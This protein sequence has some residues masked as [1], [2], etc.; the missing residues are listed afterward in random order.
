MDLEQILMLLAQLS[1][2]KSSNKSDLDVLL[3]P[4]LG[5]F[6]GTFQQ[7][8]NPKYDQEFLRQRYMPVSNEIMATSRPDSV[9]SQI[10]AMVGRGESDV[11]IK[12]W[13]DNNNTDNWYRQNPD[14]PYESK[15]DLKNL[16]TKLKNEQ[17]DLQGKMLDASVASDAQSVFA[18][19]G[20]PEPE[21][22]YPGPD[23]AIA[24]S[25]S[26]TIGDVASTASA[27]R[28]QEIEAERTKKNQE[29][30]I[31]R[32]PTQRA[33]FAGQ[34]FAGPF[35]GAGAYS[36]ARRNIAFQIGREYGL[37]GGTWWSDPNARP[38]G[39]V[40]QQARA[41]FLK[42]LKEYG[43]D[44]ETM[45]LE[46]EAKGK[47]PV[48]RQANVT[49]SGYMA[50]VSPSLRPKELEAGPLSANDRDYTRLKA[51]EANKDTIMQEAKR[52]FTERVRQNQA[53]QGTGSPLVD[54]IIRRAYV[55]RLMNNG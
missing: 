8:P 4:E 33:E 6:S 39:R 49:P 37:D 10:L 55:N 25:I 38:T 18:K 53:A 45:K 22:G 17:F 51:F 16:V 41:A 35:R 23:E 11:A 24:E 40:E 13:I 46:A 3:S 14:E 7:Q 31:Y 26:Q 19:A 1:D 28:L 36:D 47:G 48:R 12:R 43:Y 52:L 27:K 34:A 30:G 2:T 42:K 9:R 15:A 32:T 54:A 5:I 21:A 44:D 20:L 50:G 29:M